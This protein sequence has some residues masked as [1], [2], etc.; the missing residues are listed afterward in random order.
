MLSWKKTFQLTSYEINESA[1]YDQGKYNCVMANN[2][3]VCVCVCVCDFRFA[4]KL[5][6]V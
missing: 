1:R 6:C 5:L 2:V 4:L 3:C